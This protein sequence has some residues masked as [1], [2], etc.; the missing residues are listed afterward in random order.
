MCLWVRT[1]VYV[2]VCLCMRVRSCASSRS[3]DVTHNDVTTV[4][5]IPRSMTSHAPCN[6]DNMSD[7]TTPTIRMRL[8]AVN[9]CSDIIRPT[10]L[11]PRSSQQV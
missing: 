1:C 3:S 2:R 4:S 8:C 6:D 11:R 9:T 5:H 7:V 10:H